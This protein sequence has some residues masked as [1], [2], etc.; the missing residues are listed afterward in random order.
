LRWARSVALIAI[1]SV[2]LLFVIIAGVVWLSGDQLSTGI[3]TAALEMGSAET[4]EGARRVDIWRGAWR[5]ARAHPIAGA[6]LGGFW[7][8]FPQHHDASGAQ[9]PKQAHNDYLELLASGGLIGGVLLLWFGFELIRG[10]RWALENFRGFQRAAALGA[11]VG[12]IGVGVH[13]LVDFGLHITINA[14]VFM[15]LLAILSINKIN[16]RPSAQAHRNRDV[17]LECE[18]L[19]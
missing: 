5:M 10:A 7:A 17:Q 15:M 16:Q 19:H 18:A 13:S 9:T 8:E 4:H 14:L 6:G 3:E 2:A 1:T 12:I 11:I